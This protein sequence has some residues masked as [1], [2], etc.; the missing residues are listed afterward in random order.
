VAKLVDASVF[1][2]E[3]QQAWGCE[4]PL[5]HQTLVQLP[6]GAIMALRGAKMKVAEMRTRI[7]AEIQDLEQKLQEAKVKLAL[8]DELLG[9][10]GGDPSGSRGRNTK[11]TVMTIVTE[12]DRAGVTPTEVVEKAAAK[13]KSLNA[14]SVASLL[15]KLKADK[16][17]VFNGMRYYV[18]GREPPEDVPAL[19]AVK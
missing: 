10:D 19:R 11:K 9:E 3:A 2:T 18:A 12:A 5:A 17:L 4:S 15:S 16:T 1:K 8:C 13:G 14:G 6:T 7:V